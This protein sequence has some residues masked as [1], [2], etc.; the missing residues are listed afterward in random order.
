[1]PASRET[2][3]CSYYYD[4]LDR[5][6]ANAPPNTPEHQR[7]YC[8]SRLATEIQGALRYSI[9]QHG[10]QL[11]AQKLDD[12]NAR[13]ATLLATDQ[14]RSVLQIHESSD[15]GRSIA[16]SPYGHR[17]IENGL[18]SL[19]G[20]NGE[21][22]DPATGHYLL[23]NGYR[24]F[25]PVLMR[26]NTPDSLSPFEKGGLNPYAYC[27]GDPVN[28]TDPNGHNPIATAF[29]S[30]TES[31]LRKALTKQVQKTIKRLP[32]KAKYKAMNE[33]PA[34]I[35]ADT[36]TLMSERDLLERAGQLSGRIKK[37]GL[38]DT[39]ALASKRYLH[40]ED[41]GIP[42]SHSGIPNP[43]KAI[44][45]TDK[46]G[47]KFL[48]TDFYDDTISFFHHEANKYRPTPYALDMEILA[49]E[50]IIERAKY[51]RKHAPRIT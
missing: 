50:A 31:Y 48:R 21:R 28:Q 6:I 1:M 5:L 24:A 23:G 9:I 44:T 34:Q 32:P 37:F 29:K 39:H 14:Q 4:P 17:P 38:S 16:Y 40:H 10:D 30:M 19:L 41:A 45:G 43:A 46:A 51:I 2:L 18:L 35:W 3:L 25:N 22:P 7:F 27:L 20:F 42:F 11:L 12:G 36:E 26:F 49:G 13:D 33:L 8:K 15:Q 47:Q